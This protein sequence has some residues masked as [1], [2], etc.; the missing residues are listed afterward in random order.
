MMN[1]A[2]VG[3]VIHVI[4]SHAKVEGAIRNKKVIAT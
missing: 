3:T 4:P 2:V 1:I